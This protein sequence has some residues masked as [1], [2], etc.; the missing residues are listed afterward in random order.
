MISAS[1]DREEAEELRSMLVRSGIPAVVPGD[2][3]LRAMPGWASVD[4]FEKPQAGQARFWATVA[5]RAAIVADEEIGIVALPGGAVREI[6]IDEV[7]PALV[8][9]VEA[10]SPSRVAVFGGAWIGESEPEY[11]EARTFG[12]VCAEAGIEVVNGGYG[13]IMGAVSRGASE[14]KG[15]VIGVTI[16]AFSEHVPVNRSLTHEVEAQDLFARLPLICDAEAW[17]AFPGGVGT[18][19]EVALCWSLVQTDSVAPRPLI[20]VGEQW[21]RALKAFR[22]L[23]LA[24]DVHFDLLRPAASAEAAFD[25]LREI[26]MGAPAARVS[27][28]GP[29]EEV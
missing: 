20:I 7:S 14:A 12:R 8:E 15:T 4:P 5:R 27:G 9:L 19:T 26:E 6:P 16:G 23:L 24:E 10:P 3:G 22:E 1:S 28:R 29:E 21:D 25:H 2:V 11:G 13:G 17:V 18:L